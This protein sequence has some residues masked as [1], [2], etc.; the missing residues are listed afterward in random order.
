MTEYSRSAKGSFT[1]TTGAAQVI[2]LP[3]QP[4]L[5]KLTNYTAYTNFTA[6]RI[7]WAT[8]DV[9]MGQAVAAVGYVGS[10]PVLQVGIV[11]SQGI[12]SFA[13]GQLLQYGPTLTVSG[14]V[15]STGVVT[16]SA[17]HNLVPGNVVIFSN[18]FTTAPAGMPQMAGFP[19]EVL[20]TPSATTFTVSWNTNQ[21]NYTTGPTGTVKQVLYPS[22]YAPQQ[23]VISSI[24]GS[25]FTTAAQHNFKVGQEVAFRI[26]AVYGA[27]G[28]NSLPDST[29]PGQPIYY[30]VSAATINTF[31]ISPSVSSLTGGF[32]TAIA[33][34]AVTTPPQVVSVG[35]INSGGK[36]YNG[37]AL[38][39]SPTVFSGFGTSS[40]STTNGPAIE[41]AFINNTSQ[42]FIV[43]P[44]NAVVA[45]SADTGSFLSGVTSD[46]LYWEAYLTDIASP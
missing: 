39:P 27:S 15:K 30:Y 32:T 19:I 11:S 28:L 45:S 41:G 31:T 42:G 18:L 43:G 46:V 40:N 33:V 36:I 3:F 14:I 20:T 37:G 9:V 2:Y 21:T 8:W 44:G 34:G 10:G 29:I 25:V 38:Y 24:S 22:L 26:P 23:A 13:G 16:T 1:A 17:N 5:V 35:D 6:S 12:S 7:P 4:T